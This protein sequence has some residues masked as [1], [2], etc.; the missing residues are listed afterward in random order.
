[1]IACEKCGKEFK[2]KSYLKRH[3]DAKRS[4]DDIA[5]R[6]AEEMT[7]HVCN[8]CSAHFATRQ[9]LHRHINENRC[10]VLKGGDANPTTRK[11]ITKNFD[12]ISRPGDGDASRHSGLANVSSSIREVSIDGDHN[13][14]GGVTININLPAV[15]GE[16]KFEHVDF[17]KLFDRYLNAVTIGEAWMESLKACYDSE[18]NHTAYLKDRRRAKVMTH[19]GDGEWAERPFSDV[20]AERLEQVRG[21]H[22][23]RR[24]WFWTCHTGSSSPAT[25]GARSSPRRSGRRPRISAGSWSST[26]TRSKT[27]VWSDALDRP[28]ESSGSPR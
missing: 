24:H 21:L 22:E 26:A 14:V 9:T 12:R 8:F 15:Y 17:D 18:D 3:L 25:A 7:P 27:R 23:L 13:N 19:A 6:S 5:P 4:C 28:I 16:E 1:M 20:H 11:M 10:I 2:F